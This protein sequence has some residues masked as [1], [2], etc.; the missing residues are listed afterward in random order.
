ML[1]VA[2]CAGSV[3]VWADGAKLCCGNLPVDDADLYGIAGLGEERF[4]EFQMSLKAR[5]S[6]MPT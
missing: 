3:L 5:T 4:G 1:T 2:L 6:A